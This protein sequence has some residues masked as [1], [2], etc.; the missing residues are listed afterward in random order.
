MYT[1]EVV[2]SYYTWGSNDVSERGVEKRD[3]I[4]VVVSYYT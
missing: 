2:V 3:I 4:E 1:F